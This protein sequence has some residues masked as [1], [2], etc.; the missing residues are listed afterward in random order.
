[1]GAVA[2]GL[3][4][5]ARDLHANSSVVGELTGPQVDAYRIVLGQDDYV[6][7]HVD[8]GSVDLAVAVLRPDGE[9]MAGVDAFDY[10]VEPVSIT[11]SKPG[12]YALS[13]SSVEPNPVRARY[14][15]HVEALRPSAT[16]DGDWVRA[17]QLSTQAKQLRSARKADSLRHALELYRQA[18]PLWRAVGFPSGEARTLIA[19][20]GLHTWLGDT[21]QALEP[22]NDAVTI[23]RSL[24]DRLVEAVA[25]SQLGEVYDDTGATQKALDV[26]AAARSIFRELG[27]ALLEAR[28]LVDTAIVHN[29]RSEREIALEHYRQALPVLRAAGDRTWEAMVLS[30]MGRI[31]DLLGERQQAL[32]YFY[33]S[34]AIR[35]QVG[36]RTGQAQSLSG[37]ALVYSALGEQSWAIEYLRRAL[38]LYQSTGERRGEAATL[39]NLGVQHDDMEKRQ[40]AVKYFS[41]ALALR[42][43][44]GDRGGQ[45]STLQRIG[46]GRLQA[47]DA[48]GAKSYFEDALALHQ[49]VGNREG[50]AVVLVALGNTYV[51]LGD[52]QRALSHLQTALT[53]SQVVRARGVEAASLNA[54][55]RIAHR[56]GLLDEALA[57]S[58]DALEIVESLRT[59]VLSQQLRASYLASVQD[60]YDSHIQV[61]MQMHRLR[62]GDGH[63]GV[64]LRAS[65]R[66][67]ARSLLEMLAEAQVDIRHGIDAAL[68]DRERELH[69]LLNDKTERQMRLLS[70][71][72]AEK[73]AAGLDTEIRELMAEYHKIQVQ[74][75]LT[76]PR[77]ASL[78]YP[79]PL[80]AS[81]IQQ[82][83]LDPDT[84]LLEY[85]LGHDRSYLWAV[86]SSAI[87]S[88][89]LPGRREVESAARELHEL[90][91]TPDRAVGHAASRRGP[92][93]DTS[94]LARAAARVSQMLLAPVAPQLRAKRLL[95]VTEGAVQY[96]PF[97]A[98]PVPGAPDKRPLIAD[99]EIVTAPSASTVAILRSEAAGRRAGP[100][101]VAVLA[102]P[103]FASDD[104]R[105]TGGGREGRRAAAAGEGT[106]AFEDAA[107]RQRPEV[108]EV[109]RAAKAAGAA[110]SWFRLPRLPFTR[111]EAEAILALVP[112]E[113][114]FGALDFDASVATAT[115]RALA[116]Y[117]IV[118]LATHGFLNPS[119]PDL[120]GLVLSLVDPRG[121]PQQGFLRVHDLYN[122]ELPADLVVLSA[123]RSALGADIR[124]EGL[125]GL[126]RGFMY[127]G[128]SRVAASLWKVD[129]EATAELMNLFYGALLKDRLSPAA[130][131]RHAQV[132]MWKTRRWTSPRHWAAF[133]IQGEWR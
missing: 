95:I 58:E 132:A 19:T 99:H 65:E 64:A 129:D 33:D 15:L 115:S 128:A 22:L 126:T 63:D 53:L 31:Y 71:G 114:G 118:H 26:Y 106:R 55:A 48:L 104:P 110:D 37:I 14:E 93:S 91:S 89:E 54:I 107:A 82:R 38:P 111:R 23:A 81:E 131:L 85:A 97:A 30:G 74:I 57:R 75:R 68:L 47:G 70:T 73:E 6:L 98:L 36:D 10:G 133:V 69:R 34:L 120:S 124:G 83:V 44:I 1:V 79:Q 113:D 77:Y 94:P 56:R 88:Y 67:R 25:L 76:S 20:G 78:A 121:R 60:Y 80:S 101:A 84:L 42:R 49:A 112:P 21:D 105:V 28:L 45:A 39:H 109:Q 102:D 41:E 29:S 5:D 108:R 2:I 46:R 24:G 122:L 116:Q 100:K 27:E 17:A 3:Q 52:E 32:Q 13:I 8:Q 130:A 103:V 50:E 16:K 86:S 43:A 12:T 125:V 40:E 7:V 59:R 66:A 72:Q 62:P 96:V 117:R 90:I 35:E 87:V 4:A 18:L 123:C 9:L 92:A 61:L 11:A 127:A 51:A 119:Q